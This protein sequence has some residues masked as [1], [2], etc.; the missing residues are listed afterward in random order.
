[1]SDYKSAYSEASQYYVEITTSTSDRDKARFDRSKR[2][3]AQWNDEWKKNPVNLNEIC[4]RFA[5]GDSGRKEGVKF[6]FEGIQYTVKVDMASG[7]LRI[8]DKRAKRYVKVDGS[9]GDN[10]STH[11]KVLR[12]EGM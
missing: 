3:E 12:R 10:R 8:W 11:F 7:Y 5:P 4:D 1:M 6:V 2:R 9:P